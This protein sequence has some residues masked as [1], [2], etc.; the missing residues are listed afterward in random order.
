METLARDAVRRERRAALRYQV[1]VPIELHDRLGKTRNV[2]ERGVCFETDQW[3]PRG[4][5]TTFTLVFKDFAGFPSWRIAGEGEVVRVEDH[6]GGYV[7]ALSV[8][9]YA[10]P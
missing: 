1:S 3:L 10:L 9:A 6:D 2:S 4:D 5:T 8:T 7:I